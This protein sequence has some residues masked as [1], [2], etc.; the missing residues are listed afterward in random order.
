VSAHERFAEHGTAF[1]EQLAAR[2][3]QLGSPTRNYSR[4]RQV[5]GVFRE[6]PQFH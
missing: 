1:R 3:A 2:L 6:R 4:P 5:S